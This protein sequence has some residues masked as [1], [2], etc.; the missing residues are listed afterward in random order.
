MNHSPSNPTTP[1]LLP[2]P[3]S[4]TSTAPPG[5]ALASPLQERIVV[6]L[7]GRYM[8]RPGAPEARLPNRSE[9]ADTAHSESEDDTLLNQRPVHDVSHVP[10]YPMRSFRSGLERDGQGGSGSSL[11]RNGGGGGSAMLVVD[12]AGYPPVAFSAGLPGGI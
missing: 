12:D 6:R 4:T 3:A 7:L 2:E 1:A 8:D 5:P 9:V 11:K 10:D